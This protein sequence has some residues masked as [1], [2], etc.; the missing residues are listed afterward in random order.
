V[1]DWANYL[2]DM[3]IRRGGLQFPKFTLKAN[4]MPVALKNTHGLMVRLVSHFGYEGTFECHHLDVHDQDGLLTVRVKGIMRGNGNS[5]HV[6]E[7][8]H[9]ETRHEGVGS[10]VVI[11][12]AIPASRKTIK[13]RQRAG[14][15]TFRLELFRPLT[16]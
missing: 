16:V 10:L 15:A 12:Q 8:L 11:M 9:V 5:S 1:N 13:A 3:S 2:P 7:L 6:T 14:L 4:A